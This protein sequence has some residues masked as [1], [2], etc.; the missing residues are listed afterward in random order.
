M[1]VIRCISNGIEST[2]VCHFSWMIGR[3]D[4]LDA[5]YA[6][7]RAK[8]ESSL[9]TKA[10]LVRQTSNVIDLNQVAPLIAYCH[11]FYPFRIRTVVHVVFCHVFKTVF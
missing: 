5:V 10:S 4:L 8:G 3:M 9:D 1:I 7:C 2:F 6:V 11:T